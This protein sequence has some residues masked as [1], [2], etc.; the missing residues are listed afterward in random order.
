MKSMIVYFIRNDSRG[1]IIVSGEDCSWYDLIKKTQEVL[2][3]TVVITG[4]DKLDI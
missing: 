3:E 2:G 1:Y 4:I